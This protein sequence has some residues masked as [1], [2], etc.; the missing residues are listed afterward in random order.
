[1]SAYRE[2]GVTVWSAA[3]LDLGEQD[4][5]PLL[6]FRGESF[7]PPLEVGEVFR[8]DP[9]QVAQDLVTALRLQKLIG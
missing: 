6:V 8:G 3:D 7:P 4:L 9:Q 5:K 1:M 2:W